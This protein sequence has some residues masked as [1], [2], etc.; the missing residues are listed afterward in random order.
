MAKTQ[1]IVTMAVMGLGLGAASALAWQEHGHEHHAGKTV[2][3]TGQ[4]VDV[5]CFVGHDSSGAKHE[6]CAEACAR[7]GNPLAIYDESAK[8][9]YL[10]V[11]TDHKNPNAKLMS[12]IEKKVTVKGT[13]LEK[14]GLKGIAI[15]TVQVAQ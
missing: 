4:V 3:V 12:F 10:P 15:D 1:I 6:K 7:A 13:L 9:L 11:S 5:A 2:Q 8:A 14:A